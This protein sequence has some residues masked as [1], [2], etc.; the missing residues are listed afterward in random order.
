[1]A[2]PVGALAGKVRCLGCVG[3]FLPNH[4]PLA[5][6]WARDLSV[7]ATYRSP[8]TP[9]LLCVP[10]GLVLA[11][12]G[13]GINPLVVFVV[14]GLAIV[15]LAGLISS[16]VE[17]LTDH[18]GDQWGGCLN[19]TFGNLVELVIAY[20][21]L[22]GG[23]YEVVLDGLVGGL[24]TNLLLVL[25]LAAV[26]GGLR[27]RRVQISSNAALLNSNL[28]L[29]VVMVAFV[30][31]ALNQVGM[32]RSSTHQTGYSQLVALALLVFY[33][34]SYV[35]Q[36]L[37]HGDL[38]RDGPRPFDLDQLE[39]AQQGAETS[40]HPPSKR[41]LIQAFGVLA[42]TTLALVFSSGALVDGLSDSVTRFHLGSFFTGVF[43]LPLFGSAAEFVISLR[44]AHQNRM[45]LA[46]ATT[47]GSSIQIVLFVLPVLILLGAAI[48][49]PLSIFFS[50][51]AMVTVVAAVFAV[52]WV[53]DDGSLDWFEGV[54]LMLIYI[55]LFASTFFLL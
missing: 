45:D 43:M 16:S 35:Y 22:T 42:I 9:L 28:L 15:P 53:T 36:F 3:A 46:V 50:P 30:P 8:F 40:L 2:S 12:Q 52:Q 34:L 23:L 39:P 14:N 41:R 51:E 11:H 21:A 18:L 1:M 29:A 49:R 48:G 33:C 27:H 55:L 24:V 20:S 7:M 26:V 54:F 4:V 32:F 38:F 31:S 6:L 44:A 10:L 37:T 5:T 13:H 19:A 47:V 17:E 25:G